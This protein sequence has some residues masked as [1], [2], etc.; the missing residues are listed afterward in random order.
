MYIIYP[1]SIQIILY[2]KPIKKYCKNQIAGFKKHLTS[3]YSKQSKLHSAW[4]DCIHNSKPLHYLLFTILQQTTSNYFAN[5][6]F[7]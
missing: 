3:I 1:S 2:P 5:I 4:N 7:F 6:L